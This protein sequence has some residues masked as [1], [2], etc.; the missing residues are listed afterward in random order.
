[1]RSPL[2]KLTLIQQCEDLTIK[3]SSLS[4]KFLVFIDD[5]SS[6]AYV[7]KVR[8]YIDNTA[9]G[10]LDGLIISKTPTFS[11]DVAGNNESR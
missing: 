8:D 4:V 5:K 11:F 7:G 3:S 1:M 2:R 9:E 10:K 6:T